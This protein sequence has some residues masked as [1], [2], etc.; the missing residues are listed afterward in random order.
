[1]AKKQKCPEFENHERWLV[2]FADMMTLLF[3]VFVVL[4]ALKKEGASEAKIQQ[5]AVSIQESFNDVM[6]DIPE[7]KRVGPTEQ[8]FGIFEH[9]KGDRIRPPIVT[10]YPSADRQTKVIDAEM[11]KVAEMINLRMYGKEKLRELEKKGQERIVSVQRDNDGFRVKLLATHFYK[12]GAYRVNQR[13]IDDLNQVGKILKEL[14]RDLTV[15]GHTDSVPASGEL[16]NWELSSLRASFIVRHFIEELNFPPATLAAAGYA[17]TKPIASN[18]TEET[19]A[20]NRRI[21]IKV[22]YNE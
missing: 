12:P 5:A 10:K 17:D 16:S 11:Q 20:L 9:R 15:E 21:E 19:R 22:H 4:Y 1:M 6:E 2:S 13:A 3:A 7:V 14:G 8:G 18:S